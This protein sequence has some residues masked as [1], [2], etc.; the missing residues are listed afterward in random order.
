MLCYTISMPCSNC[1]NELKTVTYDNQSILH[2]QN[3]GASFFEENGINRITQESAFQLSQ[4]TKSEEISGSEK[5]CPKD[6]T[7]LKALEKKESVPA[8]ITLLRCQTCKGIFVFPEDL[9]KFKK[10]QDVKVDY[11]KTWGI[12]LPS[13]QSVIVLSFVA[14][15]SAGVFFRFLLYQNGSLRQTQARDLI[16]N[17][18]FSKSGRYGFVSF[19]TTLPLRSL[20]IITDTKT[21]KVFT[22]QVSAKLAVLHFVTIA[23]VPFTDPIT[24]HIVL[25]DNSGKEIRSEENKLEIQ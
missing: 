4:D 24:Y 6:Q 19:K 9:V 1:G 7:V 5:K 16:K 25:I 13:L 18:S 21:N 8:E 22:K 15:I 17:V 2:C 10:A 12:P 23:D 11:F 14:L 3:C 20:I